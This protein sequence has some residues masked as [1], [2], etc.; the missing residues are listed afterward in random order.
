MKYLRKIF[1]RLAAILSVFALLAA[2]CVDAA[3]AGAERVLILKS[4]I[5]TK[6]TFIKLKDLAS[7][8][9]ILSDTEKELTVIETPTRKDETVN[10]VDIAYMLQKHPEL[11]DLNLRGPK[12][13]VLQRFSGNEY[14]EKAK[15]DILASLRSTAPWNDWEIDLQLSPSDESSINRAGAF[16][17]AKVLP[18]DNKTMVGLVTLNVAF[19]DEHE[20]QVYKSSLNP[21]IMRKTSVVVLSSSCKQGQILSE[22]SLS[23][24]SVWVGGDKKDY[25]TDYDLCVGR[26]LA[27]NMQAGDILQTSDIMNPICV[28][29]GDMMWIECKS[30]PLTITIAGTA[31]EGGRLGEVIKVKNQS[32]QKIFP[33]ELTGDKKGVYRSGS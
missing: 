1:G 29:K 15:N 31:V 3:D 32:S 24:V 21:V 14:I 5:V 11:A 10:I 28:K 27:K 18:S 12:T 17:K 33:V 25:I 16:S 13:I 6:D 19:F 20:K 8:P 2:F 22:N 9:Q 7:N 26:E 23:K 30:G 4:R